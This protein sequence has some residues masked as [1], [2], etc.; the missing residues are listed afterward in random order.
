MNRRAEDTQMRDRLAYLW[1]HRTA[2]DKAEMAEF[3]QLLT[4]HVWTRANVRSIC[5]ALRIDSRDARHDCFVNKILVPA[6]GERTG[7]GKEI[8]S[9]G[10]IAYLNTTFANYLN[11]ELRRQKAAPVTTLTDEEWGSLPTGQSPGT[12]DV[13][14]P[15]LSA[16]FE[17]RLEHDVLP[18]ATAFVQQLEQAD[19]VLLKCWYAKTPRPALYWFKR[20]VKNPDYRARRLGLNVCSREFLDYGKT[21]IGKW[22]AAL[23]LSLARDR[24]EEIHEILEKITDVALREQAVDCS[25]LDIGPP[26]SSRGDGQR[27]D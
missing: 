1:N 27:P 18:Q 12:E 21:R 20:I 13:S 15:L 7:A 24:Y 9:D 23:G 3:Y 25:E 2:L 5:D 17:R 14:N 11:D 22:A 6:R 4:S 19:L 16:E 26:A 8:Q 10:I